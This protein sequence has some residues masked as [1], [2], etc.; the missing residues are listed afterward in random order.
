MCGRAADIAGAKSVG[1]EATILDAF[2]PRARFACAFALAAAFSLL[3]SAP[4]LILGGAAPC[5]L[6]FAGGRAPLLLALLRVNLAGFFVCLLLPL[7]GPGERLWGFF[8]VDGLR[9]GLLVMYRL[10]LITVVMHRLVVSM[11]TRRIGDLLAALRLPEKLRVLLLLTVRHIS[12]LADRAVMMRR[13]VSL[14]GTRL[15]W[16][17]ACY[18]FACGV[19][20]AMVHGQDRAERS[21]VAV[22]CRGGFA[23]F[24]QYTAMAW[25]PRDTILCLACA[26]YLAAMAWAVSRGGGSL[27]RPA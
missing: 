9:L 22:E 17:R 20:S 1:A 21:R 15:S 3:R 18:A 13:A 8:S 4:G 10:N 26:V 12:I 16:R 25:Q 7:T 6:L 2:D 11:G 24:S 27:A 23:G 19:G 5:L 14:R